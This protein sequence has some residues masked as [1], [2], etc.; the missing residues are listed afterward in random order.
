MACRLLAKRNF[1]ATNTLNQA[2]RKEY[3]LTQKEQ[4]IKEH[5]NI[6]YVP[7]VINNQREVSYMKD[8]AGGATV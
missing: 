3:V 8:N 4:P 7:K 6:K 1:V 5:T 2:T